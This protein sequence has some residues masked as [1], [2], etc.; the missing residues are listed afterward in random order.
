M[1]QRALPRRQNLPAIMEHK[2]KRSQMPARL[3]FMLLVLQLESVMSIA[4]NRNLRRS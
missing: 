1:Q 2:M 4:E 3:E